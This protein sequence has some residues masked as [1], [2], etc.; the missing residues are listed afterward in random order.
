MLGCILRKH[1]FT[2]NMLGCILRKHVFT[3]DMLGCILR[4]TLLNKLRK[5]VLY[6]RKITSLKKN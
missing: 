1:I 2:N 4:K 6:Y 3:N 5:L